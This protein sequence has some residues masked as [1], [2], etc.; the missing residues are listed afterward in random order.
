MGSVLAARA[1][2]QQLILAALNLVGIAD[3]LRALKQREGRVAHLLRAAR[4]LEPDK[5]AA[6]RTGLAQRLAQLPE[7]PA[8]IGPG[9]GFK[10]FSL[11]GQARTEGCGAIAVE[12]ARWIGAPAGFAASTLAGVGIDPDVQAIA[13]GLADHGQA[14]M[15]H[16]ALQRIDR[17]TGAPVRRHTTC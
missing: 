16:P 3:Q 5:A 11:A 1:G 2:A 6:R 17:P 8:H 4:R 15:R 9:D 10:K 13:I 12:Q 14:V 7:R